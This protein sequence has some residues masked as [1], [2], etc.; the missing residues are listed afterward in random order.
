MIGK[1]GAAIIVMACMAWSSRAFADCTA[2][3]VPERLSCL[4]QELETLKT[5]SSKEIAGLKADIQMLRNELLSLR[6]TVDGLPPASSIARLDE[7]VN[8]LW[9]PQ[10]G[11]LAW[12]GPELNPA[13]E[14][15]GSM[16]V[17]APCTKTSPSSA[18]WRLRRVPLPR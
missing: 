8:L 13:P 9:E 3:I 12:T 18:R 15:G 4:N 6:Q 16:Q 5:Q 11:C 17:F 2:G 7:D 10:D 1:A 14:S